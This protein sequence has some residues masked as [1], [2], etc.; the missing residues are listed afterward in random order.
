MRAR[1]QR[2]I[3]QLKEAIG[4]DQFKQIKTERAISITVD[5]LP[6]RKW[7]LFKDYEECDVLAIVP[8]NA[9]SSLEFSFRFP[10]KKRA[11]GDPSRNAA[12]RSVGAVQPFDMG[13]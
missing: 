11:Y 10:D 6:W 9:M 1:L 4:M 2:E 7:K 12:P 13:L 8:P 3:S 5:D